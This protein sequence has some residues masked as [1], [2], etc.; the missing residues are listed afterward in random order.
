MSAEDFTNFG[1]RLPFI[2]SIVLVAMALYIR[3]RLQ[4]TPLFTKLKE[5]GQL[6]DVAVAGEFG[7]PPTAG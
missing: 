7:N 3:V 4:E 1:W 2:L 5:R 6:L